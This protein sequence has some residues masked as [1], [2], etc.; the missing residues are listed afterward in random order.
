MS[1]SSHYCSS[2]KRILTEEAMAASLQELRLATTP[3]AVVTTTVTLCPLYAPPSTP[4][5]VT[6]SPHD[7]R[8]PISC[9]ADCPEAGP[10]G[11]SLSYQHPK[12]LMSV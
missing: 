10:S 4:S 11:L 1:R 8:Y 2:A 3:A 5:A 7:N 9:G 6:L 12:V